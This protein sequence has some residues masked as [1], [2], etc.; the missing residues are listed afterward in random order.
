V[1]T[2][3]ITLPQAH[4]FH[5]HFRTGEMMELVAPY[6]AESFSV[7][8]VMPNTN[9]PILTIADADKYRRNILEA[10]TEHPDFDPK[11]T[12]KLTQDTTEANIS[13]AKIWG[14]LAGKFYPEGVTTNSEGGFQKLSDAKHLLEAMQYYDLP[15]SV[16]AEMPGVEE[17]KAELFFLE[18]IAAAAMM[19]PKLRIIVEHLSTSAAVQIVRDLPANVAGTITAHHL[20]ITTEDARSNPHCFCKPIAKTKQDR[21]ALITAAI[22]GNPKFFFGSDTAPHP[23]EAKERAKPSAGCFT[24]PIAL[25]LLTQVFDEAG[26]M[27]RLGDFVGNFGAQFY[28]IETKERPIAL[29]KKPYTVPVI[30]CGVIPFFASETIGWQIQS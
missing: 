17:A 25:Q 19:F 2:Q 6:T 24:A 21:N 12:I 14:I 22:S 30:L 26:A 28:R 3:Q 16:H 9:P 8:M 1:I 10:C 29:V 11:M 5:V 13:A 18:E 4:D 7:A 15:L 20:V 27:D 23:K